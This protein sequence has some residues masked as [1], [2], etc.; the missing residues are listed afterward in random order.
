M[1][2]PYSFF[3]STGETG[4][5][6]LVQGDIGPLQGEKI[7]LEPLLDDFSDVSSEFDVA[8]RNESPVEQSSDQDPETAPDDSLLDTSSEQENV[9]EHFEAKSSSHDDS[10]SKGHLRLPTELV[11]T[12]STSSVD[13]V[14]SDFKSEDNL[15]RKEAA[16]QPILSGINKTKSDSSQEFE[17]SN[18]PG[19]KRSST[20]INIE[21]K[22]CSP[23]SF[24]EYLSPPYLAKSF[25]NVYSSAEVNLS[26]MSL[27]SKSLDK[28]SGA[29][30]KLIYSPPAHQHESNLT[31]VDS[32]SEEPAA[33]QSPQT[34]A[35]NTPPCVLD[36]D[37]AEELVDAASWQSSTGGSVSSR[38]LSK[39]DSGSLVASVDTL[40]SDTISG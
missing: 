31:V 34:S 2:F 16:E 32:I 11:T 35:E 38:T 20:P 7:D 26:D 22:T 14:D 24:E 18:Q 19:T 28:S 25:P 6:R 29:A 15:R 8:D 12:D 37:G 39:L 4:K 33:A 30:K 10:E 23:T 5:T 1:L 9:R 36:S 40:Q 21:N 17:S 3:I 27:S 13:H